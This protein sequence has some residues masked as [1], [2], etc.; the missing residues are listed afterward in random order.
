MKQIRLL[1]I[2][3]ESGLENAICFICKRRNIIIKIGDRNKTYGLLREKWFRK[4]LFNSM[5]M[6]CNKNINTHIFSRE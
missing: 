3:E 1:F 5:C 6:G 4:K 2:R